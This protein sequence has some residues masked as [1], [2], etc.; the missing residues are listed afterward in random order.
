MMGSREGAL[1]HGRFME[2]VRDE[3]LDENES[4]SSG[5]LD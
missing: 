2:E 3:E 1:V 5:T 4:N